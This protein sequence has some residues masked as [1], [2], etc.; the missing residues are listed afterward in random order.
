MVP[1]E[2]ALKLQIKCSNVTQVDDVGCISIQW[3]QTISFPT[4][5]EVLLWISI[6]IYWM[7]KYI[8]S[9]HSIKCLQVAHCLFTTLPPHR[10]NS[11]WCRDQ[12]PNKCWWHRDTLCWNFSGLLR[13]VSDIHRFPTVHMAEI[14]FLLENL[15][16]SE[17]FL[18]ILEKFQCS[19]ALPNIKYN[20]AVLFMIQNIFSHRHQC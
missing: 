10:S 2:L 16:I 15:W 3:H 18:G 5:K 11:N 14:H 8:L 9:Q 12:M 1:D 6:W 13:D 7:I 17:P 19:S 4:F 20:C